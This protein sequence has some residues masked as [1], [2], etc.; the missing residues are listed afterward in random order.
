MTNDEI[1]KIVLNENLAVNETIMNRIF[2]KDSVFNLRH[3]VSETE[4]TAILLPI[5]T[6][7]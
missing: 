3:I 7:W 4:R 5:L 2:D 1:R 6:E